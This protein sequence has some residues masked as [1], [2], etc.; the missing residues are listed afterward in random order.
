MADGRWGPAELGVRA[1]E[2]GSVETLCWRA[3]CR[4]TSPE[5]LRAQPPG[6]PVLQ[7]DA[8]EG[9][10]STPRG[11]DLRGGPAWAPDHEI[12][13]AVNW[14]STPAMGWWWG[15]RSSELSPPSF[16]HWNTSGHLPRAS[17]P[18]AQLLPPP[19]TFPGWRALAVTPAL[20]LPFLANLKICFLFIGELRPIG[21]YV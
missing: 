8:S 16:E 5:S 10:L 2:P 1:A 20:E 15:N 21:Q 17:A 12:V 6:Q 4:H 14:S 9:P 18:T 7:L 13:Y 11:K 19:Q 3:R